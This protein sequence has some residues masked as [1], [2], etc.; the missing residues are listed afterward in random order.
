[1]PRS[2]RPPQSLHYALHTIEFTSVASWL[3]AV[4]LYHSYWYIGE[5]RCQLCRK[6]YPKSNGNLPE[7]MF[8]R[9][10]KLTMFL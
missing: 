4:C 9:T 3:S 5:Q 10:G 1:M 7:R 6:P 2:I 8:V